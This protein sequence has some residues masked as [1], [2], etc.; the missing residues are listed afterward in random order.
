MKELCERAGSVNDVVANELDCDIA[1]SVFELRNFGF[2]SFKIFCISY[3][4][5]SLA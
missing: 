1:V 2:C 3:C 4:T 5:G